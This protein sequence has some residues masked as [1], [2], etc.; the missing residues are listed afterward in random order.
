M[1]TKRFV[2]IFILVL[3]LLLILSVGLSAAQEA[4]DDPPPLEPW[5]VDAVPVNNAIPIQGRLTNAG[6]RP[7][8]GDYNLT[9]SVYYADTGGTPICKDSNLVSVKKGLFNTVIEGCTPIEIRG[10]QLYLGI[11]V[12]SDGEMTP[13]QALYPVPYA[14]SLVPGAKMIGNIASDSMLRV[15]NTGDTN[16][17]AIAG[18]AESLTGPT[19][20]VLGQSKSAEGSGGRF[21]NDDVDGVALAATGSGIFKSSAPTYLFVPGA[22]LIKTGS[23]STTG[24]TLDGSTAAIYKGAGAH[25]TSISIPITIPAVLYGQP[26]R[27]TQVTV[28]YKCPNADNYIKYTFLYK[29]TD[30][31][32]TVNLISDNDRDDP[33][34]STFAD[35]YTINTL[36]P[37]NRLS[38]NE[39]FLTL[40]LTLQY[41]ADLE[42]INIYGVRLQLEHPYK[43]D[44]Y[45]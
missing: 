14:Y 20:G 22:N 41:S 45:D 28:Y 3:G 37:D 25:E 15:K 35:S 42:F 23:T 7:L 16:S 29:T 40:K 24:W 11:E 6:G 1:N 27:V 18:I 30:A 17:T 32:T 43:S 13:R 10:Y 12:E 36:S 38:L 34:K 31:Y 19:T 33:R 9:L 44:L 2:T 26:V 5:S 8:N 21:R 39:G 4:Q